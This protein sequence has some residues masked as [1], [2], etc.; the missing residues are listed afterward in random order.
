MRA[1]LN[2]K[3][4]RGARFLSSALILGS[5]ILLSRKDPRDLAFSALG[6]LDATVSVT[7]ALLANFARFF[8]SVPMS[9]VSASVEF[10]E[11]F[12]SSASIE[13]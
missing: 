6:R 4:A 2:F 5:S 7:R 8:F 13:E 10:V 1:L 12:F 3:S 9:T 11:G